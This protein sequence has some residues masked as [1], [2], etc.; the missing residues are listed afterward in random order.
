MYRIYI[1]LFG[2][3][4]SSGAVSGELIGNTFIGEKSGYIE[5]QSPGGK[6]QIEDREGQGRAIANL[7][8]KDSIKGSRPTILFQSVP[9]MGEMT[10]DEITQIT[11]SVFEKQGF[12]N[13]PIEVKRYSG[14]PV[15]TYHSSMS[16]DGVKVLMYVFILDGQKSFFLVSATAPE[17]AYEAAKP[18]FEEVIEKLKY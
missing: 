6:W 5:I 18:L 9:K 12:Q 13:G 2:C 17:V 11:R 3:L 7:T 16:K 4:F 14:K 10:A 15:A 8:S 1:M